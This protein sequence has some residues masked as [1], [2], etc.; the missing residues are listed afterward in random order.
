MGRLPKRNDLRK[1]LQ[2]CIDR[3]DPGFID[4]LPSQRDLAKRFNVSSFVIFEALKAL[5][6]EGLVRCMPRKGAQVVRKSSD[7]PVMKTTVQT[8]IRETRSWQVAFWYDVI[9]QFEQSHP[10]IKIQPHFAIDASSYHTHLSSAA[11]E[12]WV[13]LCV[14]QDSFGEFPRVP[15]NEILE[16]E[17]AESYRASFFKPLPEASAVFSMPYAFQPPAM[18]YKCKPDGDPPGISWTWEQC[19]QWSVKNF[20]RASLNTPLLMMLLESIGFLM[21]PDAVGGHDQNLAR[22]KHLASTLLRFAETDVLLA[23]EMSTEEMAESFN[24][25]TLGAAFRTSFNWPGMGLKKGGNLRV[26]PAPVET[27]GACCADAVNIS[28]LGVRADPAAVE[29]FKYILSDEFQL[30]QMERGFALSPRAVCLQQ[31]NA[32][33]QRFPPGFAELVEF[34]RGPQGIVGLRTGIS[35]ETRRL[36]EQLIRRLALPVLS[37]E[38]NA[39]AANKECEQILL[40]WSA[41]RK[42]N[43]R[44]ERKRALHDALLGQP[45]S[46]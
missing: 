17:E 41:Q 26:W 32:D 27:G 23:K 29:W 10:H 16:R 13:M 20:G 25:G 30:L 40:D 33:P 36:L 18:I 42:D 31:V 14:P 5:E 1:L 44:E 9:A 46:V 38:M 7:A 12:N 34:L 37:R 45:V 24:S 21:H 4:R 28:M 6:N 22:L 3:G 15:V 11:R 35:V 43:E 2:Q 39:Q 8:L 19:V